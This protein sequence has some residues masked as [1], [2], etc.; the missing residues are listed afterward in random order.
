MRISHFEV[1]QTHVVARAAK[2]R[3][4]IR[5]DA[6]WSVSHKNDPTNFSQTDLSSIQISGAPHHSINRSLDVVSETDLI[7]EADW[8]IL[9]GLS[10]QGV[11]AV[12][13]WRK[14]KRTKRNHIILRFNQETLFLSAIAG[15]IH[16][17]VRPYARNPC[18][19]FKCERCGNSKKHQPLLATLRTALTTTAGYFKLVKSSKPMFLTLPLVLV[20][21]EIPVIFY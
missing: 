21:F 16:C 18:R 4:L 20:M 13:H 17:S 19:C 8:D 12:K 7:N 15:S 6:C 3:T 11:A 9:D 10:N 1:Y 2:R 14:T 5:K